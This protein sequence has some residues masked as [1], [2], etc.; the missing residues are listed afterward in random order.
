MRKDVAYSLAIKYEYECERYD[1]SISNEIGED[2]S[3]FLRN[4]H[5][6]RLS[7]AYASNKR[8]EIEQTLKYYGIDFKAFREAQH[9]IN[10]LKFEELQ[11][12]YEYY[13][14]TNK[15]SQNASTVKEAREDV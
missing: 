3:A 13:F 4:S 12:V 9:L 5:E 6:C 2:G 10:K 7:N 11:K 1:R 14:G 8:N 15:G